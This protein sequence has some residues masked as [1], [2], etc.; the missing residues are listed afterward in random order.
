MVLAALSISCHYWLHLR[1]ELEYITETVLTKS[2]Y[3]VIYSCSHIVV[4]TSTSG[5]SEIYRVAAVSYTP[6]STD[7]TGYLATSHQKFSSD[8]H[9]YAPKLAGCFLCI[10]TIAIP[11]DWT[12]QLFL[13]NFNLESNYGKVIPQFAPCIEWSSRR[14]LYLTI[15]CSTSGMLFH[16]LLS[17]GS[18]YGQKFKSV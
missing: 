6:L 12:L 18:S 7:T 5:N 15:R 16:C 8:M 3:S 13:Q 14:Y 2:I 4:C 11:E 17:N 10:L 1:G 9:L